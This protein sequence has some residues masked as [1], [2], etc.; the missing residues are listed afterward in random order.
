VK[1]LERLLGPLQ[2]RIMLMVGR[3]VLAAVNDGT[4]LQGLQINLLADETRDDVERFQNY[5]YTSHPHPG[6]EAIALSITGTR[7]HVVVIAVDDRRYRLK[8][9]QEGEV[10]MYSDEGDTIV[11]KRG[12][13]IEVTAGTKV[14]FNTPLVEMTGELHVVGDVIGQ[15][16]SLPH[17][18]HMEQG[19]GAP[20]SPPL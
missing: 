1:G 18:T 20:T 2:R 15:G 10:A 19:D 6:A 13:V 5:G 14:V 9:L 12:R 16:K 8:G 3:A 7:D 11:L 17:H 4:K